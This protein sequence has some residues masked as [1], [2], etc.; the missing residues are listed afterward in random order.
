MYISCVC[1]IHH[2]SNIIFSVALQIKPISMNGFKI[3]LIAL[4]T[5]ACIHVYMHVGTDIEIMETT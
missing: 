1:I 5:R 3:A 2:V 4:N